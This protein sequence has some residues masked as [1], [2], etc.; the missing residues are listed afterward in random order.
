MFAD[1]DLRIL[2]ATCSC[3]RLYLQVF[4]RV[5][6]S[7]YE[8]LVPVDA[9]ELERVR[10]DIAAAR[11]NVTDRWAAAERAVRSLTSTRPTVEHSSSPPDVLHWI[12]AGLPIAFSMSP[13]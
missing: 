12:P 5:P 13:F 9:S 1:D 4:R 2:P 7:A 6:G 3:G 10:V 8:Y 11:R